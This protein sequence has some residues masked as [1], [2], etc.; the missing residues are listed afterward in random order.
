MVAR[1]IPHGLWMQFGGN[2]KKSLYDRYIHPFPEEDPERQY[3]CFSEYGDLYLED[4]PFNLILPV[5]GNYPRFIKEVNQKFTSIKTELTV[6]VEFYER[7]EK[8]MGEKSFSFVKEK[9]DDG[10]V[11]K[12]YMFALTEIDT[13]HKYCDDARWA[14]LFMMGVL[15]RMWSYDEYS[16][17]G[18]KYQGK[19]NYKNPSLLE[20]ALTSL[21]V[22]AQGGV[23]HL[24]D[25]TM[26]KVELEAILL[27]N[28]IDFCNKHLLSGRYQLRGDRPS[29]TS[30]INLLRRHI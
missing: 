4:E 17:K 20:E 27:L 2:P 8:I 23:I 24:L 29:Q 15:F 9:K 19:I 5:P 13:S 1:N 28:D 12:P 10:A 6:L 22:Y 16:Y 25:E 11:Y 7:T 3:W 21:Q 18:A 26:K 30:V 14:V